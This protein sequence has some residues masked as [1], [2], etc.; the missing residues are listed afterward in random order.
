MQRELHLARAQGDAYGEAVQHLTAVAV[1]PGD[2]QRAGE[3]WIGYTVQQA[4]GVYEWVDDQLVWREPG[5]GDL[6]LEVTVRDAGDGRF[7]PCARVLV[8]VIDA[9]EAELGTHVQPLL[10]HPTIYHYG[11][12]WRAVTNGPHRLRVR[13]EPPTFMRQD[14][15]NGQRFTEPVEV[16][17][18]DVD[19]S[20]AAR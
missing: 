19:L 18:T 17:F 12:D 1:D 4:E 2:Q 6:H 7:V 5:D 10:W 14:R 9:H 16:E 13:V 11:R 3:Y 8:T 20:R 15:L